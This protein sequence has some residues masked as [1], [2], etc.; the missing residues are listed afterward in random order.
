MRSHCGQA[1]LQVVKQS[2]A[3][4]PLLAFDSFTGFLDAEMRGTTPSA[5]ANGGGFCGKEIGGF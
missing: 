3:G 4:V 5:S 1:R 2:V